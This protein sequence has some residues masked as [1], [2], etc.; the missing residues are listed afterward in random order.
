ML[1]YI[2]VKGI[3]ISPRRVRALRTGEK[4]NLLTYFNIP[5]CSTLPGS[6]QDPQIQSVDLIATQTNR[7]N[8]NLN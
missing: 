7:V 6:A 2:N 3:K 4:N 8:V 5:R 1:G